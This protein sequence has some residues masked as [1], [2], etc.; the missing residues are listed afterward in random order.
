MT[1]IDQVKDAFW[2]YV[3]KM[4]L[5]TEEAMEKIKQS[6]LGQEFRWE[7]KSEIQLFNFYF[8]LILALTIHLIY[9]K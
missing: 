2:D 4:T 8:H 5:T 9:C 1:N 7:I 6:E 3:L